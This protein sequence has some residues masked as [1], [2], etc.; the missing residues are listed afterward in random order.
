MPCLVWISAIVYRWFADCSLARG[1]DVLLSRA[2]C[3]EEE[4]EEEEEELSG[5]CG[6]G[7]EEPQGQNYYV[8][9]VTFC[10]YYTVVFMETVLTAF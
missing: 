10:Q 6:G 1:G 3:A 2:P 8:K 4:E 5:G 9:Y 7:P